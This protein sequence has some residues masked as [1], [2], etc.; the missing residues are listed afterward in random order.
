MDKDNNYGWAIG[1]IIALLVFIALS[2]N[3]EAASALHDLFHSPL[4][5]V[6]MVVLIIVVVLQ[7]VYVLFSNLVD[8][9]E[10]WWDNLPYRR[11]ILAIVFI[12]LGIIAVVKFD[13]VSALAQYLRL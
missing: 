9:L 4:L 13:L 5:I 8:R 10:E 7:G 11:P 2:V 6:G 12:T 1:V 3:R